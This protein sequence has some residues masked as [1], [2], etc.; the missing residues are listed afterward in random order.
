MTKCLR[1]LSAPAV[2]WTGWVAF[3]NG[4]DSSRGRYSRVSRPPCGSIGCTQVDIRVLLVE[5]KGT[6]V[7]DPG[8]KPQI[9]GSPL[10]IASRLLAAGRFRLLSEQRVLSD[11]SL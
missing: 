10:P 2:R 6:V 8:R 11:S 3:L 1:S 7:L 9:R 4:E 5:A